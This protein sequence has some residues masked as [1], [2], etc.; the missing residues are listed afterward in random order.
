MKITAHMIIT[1]SFAFVTWLPS[2][3]AE[4]IALELIYILDRTARGRSSQVC[5]NGRCCYRVG[6]LRPESPIES[7]LKR[8]GEL[9]I[10][11]VGNSPC[12]FQPAVSQS[13]DGP[14]FTRA[15]PGVDWKLKQKQFCQG[16]HLGSEGG[17]FAAAGKWTAWQEESASIIHPLPFRERKD[18]VH[19]P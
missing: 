10:A 9:G 12:A 17:K 5:V 3:R 13:A 15:F 2:S 18:R 6:P 19:L 16:G 1:I 7:C 14:F 11:S 8:G 4:K